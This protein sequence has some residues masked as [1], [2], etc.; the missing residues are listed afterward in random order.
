MKFVLTFF[1]IFI[2]ILSLVTFAYASS[3]SS[4]HV[5]LL[6]IDS[7]KGEPYNT[8]RKSMITELERL[9]YVE[10]KNL[11]I[12][13]YS[14]GNYVGTGINIWKHEEKNK[15]SDVIFLNGTTATKAFKEI[16]LDDKNKF[17]FA[18]VTDPVGV[19][20][21]DN[22]KS[23]P[24]HNFTGVSYP[25]RIED[26][27]RF[28]QKVFPKAKKIGLIYG[29]LPQSHSYKKWIQNALLLEEFKNLEVIFREVEFV[30]SE[31][32]HKRMARIAKKYVLELDKEVDLFL[33]PNDTMGS[34]KPFAKMV[35]ENVTK[36]LIGLGR[37]D[38]MENWGAT[39][40]IY[41]SLPDAGITAAQ[42]IY[43]LFNGSKIKDIIP[44]WPRTGVTFD[45]TKAKE[46][47]IMIPNELIDEA[48]VNIK[49]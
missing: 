34:Q 30:K 33:S 32:G 18:N 22:F 49:Y 11:T 35:Y 20:V 24:K 47:G 8:V 48:G 5:R 25:V 41:P 10:N 1:K 44:Q 39:M 19:G 7:L 40:S 27:L 21:I 4:L 46:F 23:P 9:G 28:I 36:P 3:N 37:K 43:K 12:K 42:M 15:R 26:R 17:V 38:V 6:I 2:F 45:L 31:G 16:A 14:L 29:N 13:Y